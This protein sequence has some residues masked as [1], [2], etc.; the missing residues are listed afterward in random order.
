MSP[1]SFSLRVNSLPPGPIPKMSADSR[2]FDRTTAAR[3]TLHP[4]TPFPKGP[5]YLY[6]CVCI[7][8]YIYILFSYIYIYIYM[9]IYMVSLLGITILI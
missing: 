5:M 4:C 6:M 9:Y 1:W 2:G 8:I 7:Y 3:G